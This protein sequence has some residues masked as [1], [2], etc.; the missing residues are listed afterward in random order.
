[1]AG[2]AKEFSPDF[3]FIGPT[4]TGTTSI[5]NILR[6]HPG[7]V[8]P[9]GAKEVFYYDRYHSRGNDWH[10]N[11]FPSSQ[12]GKVVE[13]S[14]S[15]FPRQIAAFRVAQLE[16]IPQII[17]TLRD[18]IDRMV[19][20]YFHLLKGGI[21]EKTLMDTIQ[22]HP[23][24]LSSNLFASHLKFWQSCCGADRVKVFF[25]EDMIADV[26]GFMQDICKTIEVNFDDLN[27]SVLNSRQNEAAVPRSRVLAELA[28]KGSN[29]VRSAGGHGIVNLLRET[30]L[31]RW[32]GGEPPSKEFK[33]KI[34]DEAE[35]LRPNFRPEI[36]DLQALTSRSLS[37]WLS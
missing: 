30:G 34:R 32:I 25:Q 10:R 27:A 21:A 23:K 29:A 16:S 17:V 5:D 28:R 14:P 15:L 36:E 37:H 4:K 8:L 20:Q 1:M 13:V 6:T 2:G 35:R 18:P 9:Q 3:L 31:K 26:N 12:A 7:L 24:L 33:A 11:H 19:S 22:R